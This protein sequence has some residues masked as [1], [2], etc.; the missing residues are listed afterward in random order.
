MTM[1][2]NAVC[3]ALATA[4][5]GVSLG[6]GYTIV[7][8]DYVPDA[9]PDMAFIVADVDVEYDRT[10]R[11]GCDD[12]T[13]VCRLL[14]ARSTD[15]QAIYRMRTAMNGSAAVVSALYSDRT[16]GG[17]CDDLRVVRARGNRLYAVG[18]AEY[19]GAEFDVFITGDGS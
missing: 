17:A 19:Y 5:N 18:A 14:V 3:L 7:A 11:R 12:I 13:I 8:F 15:D 16:L 4:V 2:I 10:F 1:D 9:I 6:D